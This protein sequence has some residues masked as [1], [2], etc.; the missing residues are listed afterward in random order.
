MKTW[1]A[2]GCVL[3]AGIFWGSMGLFVRRLNAAGLYAI[4]VMQLRVLASAI[5]VGLY[6]L[7]FDRQK[8]RLRPRD[9]WCFA[10]SGI[11]SLMLFSWCYF[12]G[13]QAASLAVMAVLL[14]T[15][16]VFVMLMSI[17][18]FREKLTGAKLT[19]LVLCL[20]GCVLVSGVG[21]SERLGLR[22]LLLG[23]GAGFGYALYSIFGRCAIDRG[24]SSWTIT[25]YTFVFCSLG[26]APLTGWRLIA[27]T[28]A[29]QPRLIAWALA[30]AL[31]TGFLAY[32]LYTKGLEGMPSS[33]ASILASVEPV[34]SAVIGTIVFHEPLSLA[35][36]CGILLVLGGIAVL[37]VR[38]PGKKREKT[39]QI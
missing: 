24:Y 27:G 4:D 30:M 8:L 37:S 36:V 7:L 34:T 12:T 33:R 11:C 14:Y 28:L 29:A 20:A 39:G 31:L 3:L 18:F 5:F 25:F 2:T 32:I 22:G 15:A 26:C 9:I 13:M 38:L 21:S 1:K 19:A 23:L 6:L 17:V 10:G 16:P 35:A